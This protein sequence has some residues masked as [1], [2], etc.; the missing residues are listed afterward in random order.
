LI[1]AVEAT[2]AEINKAIDQMEKL[3]EAT[4]KTGLDMQALQQIGFAGRIAGLSEQQFFK[5]LTNAAAKLEEM[6]RRTTTLSELLDANSLKYRD[7]QGLVVKIDQGLALAATLMQRA[8]NELERIEIAK[9]FGLTEQW[10]NVLRQ[11]P[12]EFRKLAAA[13]KIDPELARSVQHMEEI[14]RLV[15][16]IKAELAGWGSSL[17]Q[18]VL[19][20]LQSTLNILIP[21]LEDFSKLAKG[22]LIED[23]AA[24]LESGVKRIK[25]L[26]DEALKRA[27]GPLRIGVTKVSGV[28]RPAAGATRDAFEREAD[29]IHK[30]TA[31]LKQDTATMFESIEVREKA[32]AETRL[33]EAATRDGAAVT[34]EQRQRTEELSVAMGKAAAAQAAAREQFQLFR[35]IGT[36]AI[37]GFADALVDAASGAKTFQDAFRE[38]TS[39]VLKDIARLIIKQGLVS[40]FGGLGIPGFAPGRM[41]G[42]PVIAGQPYMVGEGGRELFVPEVSGMIV[43]NS[44]LRSGGGGPTINMPINS[45]INAPAGLNKAELAGVLALERRRMR[46]EIVPVVK[47]AL[48]RG[49][50]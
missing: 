32:R 47:I 13:A 39:A 17:V 25:V 21:I 22:G 31:L 4:R 15:V 26:T 19:P 29:S 3:G 42:G 49:A 24:N 28:R 9:L 46:S 35:Q 18:Q 38:M 34:E 48:G 7:Q 44:A 6:N 45:T 11:G 30:H 14:Q 43:P 33:L 37:S 10:I 12:E 36:T 50:L 8:G 40:A 20:A 1:K 41:A 2:V 23:L 27:E 16:L 5:D